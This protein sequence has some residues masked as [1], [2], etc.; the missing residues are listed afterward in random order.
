A[1][2]SDAPA[3][4]HDVHVR[5]E[6]LIAHDLELELVER[7]NREHERAAPASPGDQALAILAES[8]PDR[9]A[10]ALARNPHAMQMQRTVSVGTEIADIRR[11]D[12]WRGYVQLI[13][14]A[15]QLLFLE[16]AGFQEPR[17][18]DAIVRQAETQPGLVVILVAQT[19]NQT[20]N[21]TGIDALVSA[22]PH[23]ASGP[24]AGPA[25]QRELFTRLAASIPRARLGLYTMSG[26]RVCSNLLLVDDRALSIGS[27]SA[28]P[29]GFFLDTELNLV[30]EA[31]SVVRDLRHRLWAHDLALAVTTV[32]GWRPA[33]FVAQ[34]DAVARDNAGREPD[35]QLG[36]A[37]VPFDAARA[38]A[39]RA[40]GLSG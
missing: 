38:G 11:D 12:I 34:W 6:G 2:S 16:T 32:A 10:R 1:P 36:E 7:W 26:R 19:E 35:Q 15:T 30:L 23:G 27:A 13:G 33:D 24:H 8:D 3:V 28:T 29:R 37:V 14:C 39:A 25:M 17:L 9:S 4:W 40:S 5:V 18:A 20:A 31:P 22:T 21:Q